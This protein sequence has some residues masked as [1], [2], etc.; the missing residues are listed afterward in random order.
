MPNRQKEARA[1]NDVA[2]LAQKVDGLDAARY[3]DGQ[4]QSE[5]R[6]AVERWPVLARLMELAPPS[7]A[8][9]ERA[10]AQRRDHA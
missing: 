8:A 6:V 3:F 1:A 7:D 9:N 5:Y 2:A 10:S 4:E